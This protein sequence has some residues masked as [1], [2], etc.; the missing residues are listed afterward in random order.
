[1]LPQI[2]IASGA[3]KSSTAGLISSKPMAVKVLAD[4]EMCCTVCVPLDYTRLITGA[5][6]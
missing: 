5:A 4:A 1:M 6:G 2:P 3:E